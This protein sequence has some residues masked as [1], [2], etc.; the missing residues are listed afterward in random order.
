MINLLVSL[1][2]YMLIVGLLY[3][4]AIYVIDSVPLPQ[5]ANRIAKIAL[6]VLMVLVIILILLQLSGLIGSGPLPELRPR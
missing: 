4:V 1:I 2:I 5:P 3:W 6:T